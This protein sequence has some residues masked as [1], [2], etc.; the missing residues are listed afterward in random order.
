MA[1][2]DGGGGEGVTGGGGE[3][4]TGGGGEG[5]GGDGM[6]WQGLS[7]EEHIVQA[8]PIG[9]DEEY[10]TSSLILA[11][12]EYTCVGKISARRNGK[13]KK[14]KAILERKEKRV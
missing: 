11:V 12:E 14:G 4:V 6:G 5:G 3:G 8:R 1:E 7:Q 2:E 9:G 10:D 13:K